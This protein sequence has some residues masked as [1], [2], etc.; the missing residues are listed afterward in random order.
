M[1][2]R[3]KLICNLLLTTV[4]VFAICLGGYS[5]LRF[6]QE[7]FLYSVEKSTPYQLRSVEFEREL[8]I[9]I[10]NLLKVNAARTVDEYATFRANA[11]DSIKNVISAQNALNILKD[12]KSAIK[13]AYEFNRIGQKIIA[14]STAR[15]DNENR[16]KVADEKVTKLL[17]E[18]SDKLK[19]LENSI[20]TLQASRSAA[21][22]TALKNSAQYSLDLRKQE[23]LRNQVKELHS[24]ANALVG[25]NS[26]ISFRIS[27]GKINT[28]LG[29]IAK[30]KYS[31]LLSADLKNLSEDLTEL[32]ALQE[33]YIATK[34]PDFKKWPIASLRELSELSNS[35]Q[36]TLNQDIEW[37]TAK[38]DIETVRQGVLFKES[39]SSNDI[40][41]ANSEIKAMGTSVSD[42]VS[43]LFIASKEADLVLKEAELLDLFTKIHLRFESMQR[44]LEGINATD[45]VKKLQLVHAFFEKLRTEFFSRNGIV[46]ILKQRLKSIDEANSLSDKL[47]AIAITQSLSGKKTSL[48]ARVE[49][50]QAVTTVNGMIQVSLERIALSGL[51]AVAIGVIFGY[52]ILRSVLNPLRIIHMA[53]RSQKEQG[54]E[55]ALL[56][57]AVAGGDLDREV[58]IGTLL[59]FESLHIHSD[60]FGDVLRELVV[61]NESQV[62][63]DEAF[64]G[65]TQSLRTSRDEGCKRDRLKNGLYELNKI[66]RS[67][68]SCSEMVKNALDFVA[69]HI[70]A[71]VAIMY[72]YD[73][74][75]KKLYPIASYAYAKADL[76]KSEIELGENLT[77]QVALERK[78]IILNSVPAGYLSINSAMGKADP[79]NVA[80]MPI[81][82]NDSLTGV[83]ELGSF[84]Q[85]ESNDFDF[86][87]QALEGIAIALN[88][89]KSREIVNGLLE[90]TQTQ[91][92]ELRVQQ[93][94]LQQTNEELLERTRM[95]AYTDREKR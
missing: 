89:N 53:I 32:V 27:R 21:F 74:T 84:K 86:L 93:E 47:H 9:C 40:L 41:L 28:L 82:H 88:V 95:L 64:L 72:R 12:E 75:E 62:K 16:V 18:S 30:S 79:F 31:P 15:I 35:L 76:L 2:I 94:E 92:E 78:P 5:S 43:R 54:K 48:A 51:I 29:R 8:Q 59:N 37:L 87:D 70:G 65:M 7:N 68:G 69:S 55:K 57:K 46:D 17:T 66:L 73:D 20:K 90:H 4:I 14:A 83:L 77:G 71:G 49:Q 6:I 36:L 1:T 85:F 67:E 3:S 80:I 81:M 23:E 25:T 50:E 24:V 26:N 56:A 52:W 33:N 60:E 61:M 39:N 45:D 34:D 38:V 63:L 10:S 13:V 22:A 44:A 11:E 19:E 42:E 91:A 58:S